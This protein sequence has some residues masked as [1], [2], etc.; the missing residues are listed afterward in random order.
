MHFDHHDE[1]ERPIRLHKHKQRQ[2]HHSKSLTFSLFWLQAD[3]RKH[4]NSL[5]QREQVLCCEVRNDHHAVFNHHMSLT[6]LSYHAGNKTN[7]NI[8]PSRVHNMIIKKWK[9]FTFENLKGGEIFL[10]LSNGDW[11]GNCVDEFFLLRRKIKFKI[12]TWLKKVFDQ[13]NNLEIS[14]EWTRRKLCT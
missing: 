10:N 7:I 14:G 8:H 12:W 2:V 1:V 9:I 11:F 3:H 6:L 4:F 5:L 13:E